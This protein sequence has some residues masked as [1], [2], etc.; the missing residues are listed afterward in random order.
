MNH[1]PLL[2][3]AVAAAALLPSLVF[4]HPGHGETS[5]F[6]AGAFHPLS[7]WD[8]LA[9]FIAVGVLLSRLGGRL[10]A[11]LAAGLLGLMVAAGTS[12]SDGWRF[13]A[14]FLLTGASLIAAALAIART[15]TRLRTS[16]TTA[17]GPRSPT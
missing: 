16:S 17:A 13:A 6:A 7:G 5:S 3:L 11:P 1:R 8:H 12:E 4:A 15:A 14:G 9:G 10:L 2:R